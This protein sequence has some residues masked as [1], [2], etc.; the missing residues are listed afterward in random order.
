MATFCD[1]VV[2]FTFRP[3]SSDYSRGIILMYRHILPSSFFFVLA[4]SRPDHA[5]CRV[6]GTVQYKQKKCKQSRYTQTNKQHYTKNH[7]AYATW[8][9]VYPV[10]WDIY[11]YSL[12]LRRQHSIDNMY[13]T[14]TRLNIG[15]YDS[16][17]S[18]HN[19]SISLYAHWKFRSSQRSHCHTIS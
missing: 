12:H 3:R 15:R 8:F 13:D 11:S 16:S 2:E 7:V 18:D 9:L 14:V 4:N 17:S 10:L 1:D 19:R 6:A 5:L